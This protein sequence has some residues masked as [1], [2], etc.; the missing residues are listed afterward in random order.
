MGYGFSLSSGQNLLTQLGGK[1]MLHLKRRRRK[2]NLPSFSLEKR[3]KQ[4]VDVTNCFSPPGCALHSAFGSDL[5]WFPPRLLDRNICFPRRSSGLTFALLPV[6]ELLVAFLLY[7][8]FLGRNT[9]RRCQKSV[10]S[11]LIS[12]SA[13][14]GE[15]GAKKKKRKEKP[16]PAWRE[17]R[18]CFKELLIK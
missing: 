3:S 4:W 7:F 15:S 1:K 5:L 10:S 9:D 11:L 12:Q 17:S 6:G 13:E 14:R 8:F 18:K 16:E 2:K